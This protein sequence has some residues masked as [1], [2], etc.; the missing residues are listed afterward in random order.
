MFSEIDKGTIIGHSEA[1]FPWLMGD[2]VRLKQ[3]LINL[4]KNALKFTEQGVIMISM[5][6][7]EENKM[8]V[9]HIRDSG[10]GIE[11]KNLERLFRR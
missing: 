5:A 7:D 9:L 8:L 10:R 3:I 11:R 2:E 4:V 6:Y 1:N